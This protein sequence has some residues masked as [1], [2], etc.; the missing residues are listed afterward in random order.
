MTGPDPAAGNSTTAPAIVDGVDVD[1]L[2]LALA[3]CPGVARVGSSGPGALATYLPGRRVPGIRV[4]QA[5]LTIEIQ[6][7]WNS[8][9]NE[10]FAAV[11]HAAG[12]FAAGRRIDVAV[13]DIALPGGQDTARLHIADGPAASPAAIS[14]NE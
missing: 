4:E 2:F 6:A 10:L 12:P 8:S 9:K 13:V 5:T 14:G 3:S 11:K 7:D 1:G